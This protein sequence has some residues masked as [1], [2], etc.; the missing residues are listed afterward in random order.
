VREDEGVRGGRE[1]EADAV[2]EEEEREG[3][4]IEEE[5]VGDVEERRFLMV[6]LERD[7]AGGVAEPDQVGV[8]EESG[9]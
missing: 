9:A 1:A 2:G 5:G 7:N 4:G 3:V 8:R 6:M